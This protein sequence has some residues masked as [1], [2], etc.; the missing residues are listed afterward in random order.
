MVERAVIRSNRFWMVVLAVIGAVIYLPYL[1]S[2]P[3]WDPWEP[4]YT[5]VAW[6]MREH[7]T[8]F[9]PVYRG[10]FTWW[11]KPIFLLWLIRL[12][13]I[14]WDSASHFVDHELWARLPFALLAI[15]GG[16]VQ[17]DWV[18]RLYG[19]TAGFVAGLILITAPQ[20]VVIGRQ[21]MID[22]VFVVSYAASLGYLAVG[23]FTPR[24]ATS[25]LKREGPFIAFWSLEAVALLA[26][27]FV[28]QTL[29]VLV[30]GGYAIATFRW[31]DYAEEWRRA[32]T[33]QYAVRRSGLG[34]L[35]LGAAVGACLLLPPNL[36]NEQ[37][38]LYRALILMPALLTLVLV[39]FREFPLARHIGN[40]LVRMRAAWGFPLFLAIGAP[41]YAFMTVKHGWPYWQ[42]FIFYHHLGRAAGTIDK[43]GNTFDYFVRQLA[44]ATFPWSAFAL[45]AFWQLVT[46]S[47]PLRSIAERRNFFLLVGILLPFLFFGLSGTKFAH[48]I[49]PVVPFLGA[50]LAVGIVWLGRDMG[51][52]VL[53]AEDGPPIGPAV[54][55]QSAETD[56]WWQRLGARGDMVV[57]VALALVTFGLVSYDLVADFRHIVRLF[58]YYWN[59][60]TPQDYQP[61]IELQL[62]F[63]PLGIT[64]G[65]LL[66]AR[67]V[68]RIHVAVYGF[69][70]VALAAY[71]AWIMMPA[72]GATYTYKP[73]YTAYEAIAQPG[74]PVG[75]Y[76]DWQQPERS[77]IF[78][79]QNRAQH[80]NTDK[81][82]ADFLKRP[83]R[84]FVIVD[85]AKL[86]ALRRVAAK[87]GKKL[88]VVAKDHPYAMLVSDVPRPEDVAQLQASILAEAPSDI[89]AINAD[90]SGKVRLV[91]VKVSE[92]HPKRGDTVTFDVYYRSEQTVD[93]DWQIFVHGDGQHGNSH[94]IVA[95]HYPLSGMHPTSEWKPG[96]VVHDSFTLHIPEHYPYTSVTVWTGWYDGPQRMD[97]SGGTSDGD[98]RIRLGQLTLAK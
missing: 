27:G 48:Y 36:R 5:Q 50:A 19:R 14:P 66:L 60:G 39:V 8:W 83:G 15:A 72:L 78:L 71:Y 30:V 74:E 91:G 56:S 63:F 42:E 9:D 35:V 65:A 86:A 32:W 47:S 2:Y 96:E 58:I 18:R 62:F 88:Y 75:Q 81:R 23:L 52:P 73:I 89:T 53:L 28:A 1:G 95:D 64:I 33:P 22:V 29:V 94:R 10:E 38:L 43:P 49:F 4:H 20:Y 84:K 16:L 90:F 44:Y 82:A 87:D 46:R 85:S 34:M 12:G 25:W 97:V 37:R 68:T 67:Y 24:N 69:F 57:I 76:N 80:L 11:S 93:A 51:E 7:G 77:V 6:E 41:W 70:A 54:P 40:V 61:F 45:P 92:L 3:L 98:N 17:F 79:F 59:R 21:V 31:Q 26:K 13:L 55:E